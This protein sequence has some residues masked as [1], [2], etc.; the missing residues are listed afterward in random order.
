MVLGLGDKTSQKRL[1]E[2]IMYNPLGRRKRETIIKTLKYIKGV[3]KVQ[4]GNILSTK[5]NSIIWGM[6]LS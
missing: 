4:D 3:N 1:E 2:L 5:L 6:T